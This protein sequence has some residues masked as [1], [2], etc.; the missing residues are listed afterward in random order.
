MAVNEILTFDSIGKENGEKLRKEMLE[1]AKIH[2][3]L[4]ELHVKEKLKREIT[5]EEFIELFKIVGVSEK[6]R[7]N[8]KRLNQIINLYSLAFSTLDQIEEIEKGS[9]ISRAIASLA[10]IMHKSETIRHNKLFKSVYASKSHDRHQNESKINEL[11]KLEKLWDKGNWKNEG[12][13][14]Y[15]NF[16]NHVIYNDLV[17][18]IS[19]NMITRHIS[20]YDKKL[21]A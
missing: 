7:S 1:Q 6:T 19:F 20:K 12:R 18:N 17:E 21:S 5:L 15:N 8:S 14:K 9:V 16:A 10:D 2:K 11:K 13:G 4:I 3:F